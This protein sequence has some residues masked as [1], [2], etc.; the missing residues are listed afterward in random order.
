MNEHVY[1]LIGMGFFVVS[2][3]IYLYLDVNGKLERFKRKKR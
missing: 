1:I 3:L 2:V